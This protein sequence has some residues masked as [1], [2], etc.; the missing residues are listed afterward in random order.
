MGEN[1][2]WLVKEIVKSSAIPVKCR[3]IPADVIQIYRD[4]VGELRGD[5]KAKLQEEEN[6]KQM[7]QMEKDVSWKYLALIF[8]I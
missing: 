2:R 5:V 1:D 8:D 4:K 7:D 3:L 6:E